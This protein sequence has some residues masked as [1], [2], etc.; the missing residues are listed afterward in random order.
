[1]KLTIEDYQAYL[2]EHYAHHPKGM[3]TGLFMKLAEEVGEVAE[4]L[5]QASGRKAQN[6]DDLDKELVREI[7]DVIHY[8]VALSAVKKL[9]LTATILEKDKSASIKYQH[10]I[11]LEEFIKKRGY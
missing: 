5:N 2:A 10:D 4:V 7:A 1:M 8:A 11:H 3:E 9:D 6:K